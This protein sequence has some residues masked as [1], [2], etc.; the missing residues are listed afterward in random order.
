[1][2]KKNNKKKYKVI[3]FYCLDLT[4]FIYIYR[5]VCCSTVQN[6]QWN[7]IIFNDNTTENQ[8]SYLL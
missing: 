6:I 5:G 1:M 8:L 2:T 4:A 7:N 3:G